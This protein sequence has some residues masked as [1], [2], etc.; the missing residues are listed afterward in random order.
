MTV[1]DLL[2]AVALEKGLRQSTLLSYERHLTRLSLLNREVGEVTEADALTA[3][4]T[5]D[6]P[7]TRRA[8]VIALRS[9]FGWRLKI[10]KGVP[11]RYNLPDEDT[12]RL[13]LMTTPHEPR[14]L[15]MMY[16]GL[17]IGE[18]C[19]VTAADVAG[20]RLRVDKQVQQLHQTG[21]PTTL[22]V[23]PVK[24]GVADVVIPHWLTSVILS[25]D[26]TAK[27]DAVRES[28]RRAGSKVGVRLNPHL[29]RHWYA[30]T[31]I[32]RG[33]PLNVV[34]E[35]MRHSDVAVTLRTYS[36]SNTAASIHNALG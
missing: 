23:G 32:A 9:V 3:L 28:L 25:L 31:L 2:Y 18:A 14:G 19:A 29:M 6:N 7:N 26:S 33:V 11:R 1:R 13:A 8:A 35:Q 12:L 15:L 36:Q 10:P 30:T 16:A 22:R 21:K 17:R 20:D 24:T 4:W 34:S 27:P 5:I